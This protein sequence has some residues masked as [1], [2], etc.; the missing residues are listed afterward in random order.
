[1]AVF[2][3]NVHI[4]RIYEHIS[5]EQQATEAFEIYSACASIGRN[6]H[7]RLVDENGDLMDNPFAHYPTIRVERG[8]DAYDELLSEMRRYWFKSRWTD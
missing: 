2:F 8:D 5:K 3:L 7:V 1:M 6:V 4:P